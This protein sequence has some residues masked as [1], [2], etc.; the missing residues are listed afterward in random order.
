VAF[1]RAQR[2]IRLSAPAFEE[3]KYR[4]L[5]LCGDSGA[6]HRQSPFLIRWPAFEEK[7][8]NEGLPDAAIAAL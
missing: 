6:H 1:L 2:K 5:P 4:C 8:R 3:K 7:M